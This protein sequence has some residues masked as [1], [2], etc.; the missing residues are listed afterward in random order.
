V[1]DATTGIA[2][3]NS[4]GVVDFSGVNQS[5]PLGTLAT[6]NG[7]NS[8]PSVA[9]TSATDE[10]VID[11]MYSGY[12]NITAGADQTIVWEHDNTDNTS[13]GSSTE[14]GTTSVTMSWT[15][16]NT[17]WDTRWLIGAVPVKPA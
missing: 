3:E 15:L 7:T 1:F 12:I 10:L 9:V 6:A 2:E 13:G 8:T 11:F 4:W 14:P 5:T 17:G 16:A